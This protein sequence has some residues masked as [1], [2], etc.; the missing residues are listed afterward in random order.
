MTGA[1]DERRRAAAC[2]PA[3]WGRHPGSDARDRPY[4]TP[5]TEQVV[6]LRVYPSGAAVSPVWVAW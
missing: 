3:P 6:P 1:G 5:V 2:R 4:R